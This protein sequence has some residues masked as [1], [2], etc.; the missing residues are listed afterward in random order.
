M[1]LSREAEKVVIRLLRVA[2][3]LNNAHS[4]VCGYFLE[5]FLFGLASE[6][7]LRGDGVSADF[8]EAFLLAFGFR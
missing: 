2:V 5:F 4:M 8:R 1:L 3:S 7:F 6:D